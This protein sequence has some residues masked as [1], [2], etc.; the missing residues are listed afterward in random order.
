MIEFILAQVV[1]IMFS[2]LFGLALKNRLSAVVTFL[3]GALS[4]SLFFLL[5][6]KSGA[7]NLTNSFWMGAMIASALL[8]VVS[9]LVSRSVNRKVARY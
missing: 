5:L 8:A 6:S 9:A 1:L 4:G 2:H 3:G 7:Y